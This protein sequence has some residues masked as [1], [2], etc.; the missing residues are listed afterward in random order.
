[1][2]A[3][4]FTTL[5]MNA[6]REE[7]FRAFA[8]VEYVLSCSKLGNRDLSNRVGGQITAGYQLSEKLFLGAGAGYEHLN[9]D[10]YEIPIYAA[11]RYDFKSANNTTY[12]DAK[13]GYSVGDWEGLYIN[14]SFGYRIG[15]GEKLGLN[16]SV[17]YLVQTMKNVSGTSG[18]ITF[19]VGI[20]F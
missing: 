2:V 18:D 15:L 17:G 11:G 8:D 10:A 9:G 4:A 13:V 7:G 16:F 1:M 20:D 19:K 14:P 12:V 5:S 6:Q 3:L